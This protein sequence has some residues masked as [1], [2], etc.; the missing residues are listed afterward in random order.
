LENLLNQIDD[1]VDNEEQL[2][3]YW[4]G[5]YDKMDL[6]KYKYQNKVLS[7]DMVK[8]IVGRF[9]GRTKEVMK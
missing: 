8:G 6:M 4:D 7:D 9:V 5:K 3:T 1:V 2:V